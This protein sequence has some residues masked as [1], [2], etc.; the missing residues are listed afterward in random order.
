MDTDDVFLFGVF[1]FSTFFFLSVSMTTKWLLQEM[2]CIFRCR[3]KRKVNDFI[4]YTMSSHHWECILILKQLF[5]YLR[6]TSNRFIQKCHYVRY[7]LCLKILTRSLFKCF[8]FAVNSNCR[9]KNITVIFP[10]T[11]F[12]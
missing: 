6:E 8:Y 7:L 11:A 2:V 5:R 3:E 10:V 1:F 4:N 9:E 12:F